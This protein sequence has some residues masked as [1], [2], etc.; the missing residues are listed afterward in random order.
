[1][2]IRAEEGEML[3]KNDGQRRGRIE[4]ATFHSQPNTELI[5]VNDKYGISLG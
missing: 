5:H 2:S 1:M 3:T 4:G